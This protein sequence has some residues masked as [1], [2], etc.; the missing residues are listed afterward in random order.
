MHTNSAEAGPGHAQRYRLG[1]SSC[2]A[3]RL[4][5]TQTSLSRSRWTM[6]ERL[7]S[8][9]GVTVPTD[10]EDHAGLVETDIASTSSSTSAQATLMRASPIPYGIQSRPSCTTPPQ[11]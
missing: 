8:D 3:T 9:V 5:C 2:A 10:A 7:P 4:K 6:T 1:R 11:E